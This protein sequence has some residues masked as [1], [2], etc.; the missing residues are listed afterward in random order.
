MF[1]IYSA[2]FQL[3]ESEEKLT[4]HVPVMLDRDFFKTIRQDDSKRRSMQ[5]RDRQLAR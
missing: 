3:M 2:P 1:S 4:Q 5:S